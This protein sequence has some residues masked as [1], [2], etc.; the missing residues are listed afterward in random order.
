MTLSATLTTREVAE[1]SV[2]VKP[3]ALCMGQL[4]WAIAGLRGSK[5]QPGDSRI[6][7]LAAQ[8]ADIEVQLRE[9]LA[10]ARDAE[11]LP[12][13]AY[14]GP[15]AWSKP[16]IREY[17]GAAKILCRTGC[18]DPA[19]CKLIYLMPPYIILPQQL[20]RLTQRLTARYRMKHFFANNE[21]SREG[22]WLH[23]LQTRKEG[24]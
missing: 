5:R 21:K 24:S 13:C 12:M 9:Q 7:R 4:L 22:F 17:G 19:F 2:T 14:W 3:V 8:V 20:Q 16:L 11:W 1:P 23:F 6:W 18:L 10:P 15:L